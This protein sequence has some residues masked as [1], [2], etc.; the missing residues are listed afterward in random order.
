MLEERYADVFKALGDEIRLSIVDM[1]TEGD[2]CGNDIL[3]AFSISQPTLSYHMKLLVSCGVV[4]SRK[5]GL[6]T[7]YSVTGDSLD[8]LRAYDSEIAVKL[9]KRDENGE[10]EE[11]EP[12]KRELESYLL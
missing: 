10:S 3:K 11:D 5:S 7:I 6:K 12:H 8:L 9:A 1:L 2:L 4:K